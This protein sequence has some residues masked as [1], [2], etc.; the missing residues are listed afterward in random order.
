MATGGGSRWLAVALRLARDRGAVGGGWRLAVARGGWRWRCVLRETEV[1]SAVAGDWR[2]GGVC[3]VRT[4]G[5][6]GWR[7]ALL[8]E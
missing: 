6:N 5:G 3:G 8:A 4:F 1:R 7:L 2:A